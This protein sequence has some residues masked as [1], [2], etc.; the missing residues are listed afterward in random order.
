MGRIILVTGGNRRAVKNYSPRS[1]AY[2]EP[3][4]AC[5]FWLDLLSPSEGLLSRISI[6]FKFHPRVLRAC[7]TRHRQPSCG[8]FGHYL[9]IQTSLLEP[10]RK[11]LFVQRDVKI[12]LSIEYLITLHKRSTPLRCL[13]SSPQV[14][15]FTRTGTL[16]LTLFDNSLCGL[17]NSLCF[18]QDSANLPVQKRGQPKKN[19]LW[20]RLRNLRAALLRNVNLLHEIAFVGAR[21]FSPEDRSAFGSVKAKISFLCDIID[22]LLSRTDPSIN[23]T[24]GEGEKKIS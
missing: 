6:P 22:G 2:L 15:G 18:E 16:L 11:S 24:F 20:W 1:L 17:I 4:P 8:D 10:S 3:T 14:S 5:P 12:F 13:L 23:V 21:F 19:P 9:F 7:L